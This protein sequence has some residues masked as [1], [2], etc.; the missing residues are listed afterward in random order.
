MRRFILLARK[1][2]LEMKMRM[3]LLLLAALSARVRAAATTA[4][5]STATMTDSL[6]MTSTRTTGGACLKG[7]AYHSGPMVDGETGA[8]TVEAC[9]G[10]CNTNAE[11]SYWDFDGHVCRLR[12]EPGAEGAVD[13]ATATGGAKHCSLGGDRPADGSSKGTAPS[14]KAH[15]TVTPSQGTNDAGGQCRPRP[16]VC[17]RAPLPPPRTAPAPVPVLQRCCRRWCS[18]CTWFSAMPRGGGG[19][20][21]GGGGGGGGGGDLHSVAATARSLS[22]LTVRAHTA[23]AHTA[24]FLAVSVP[25]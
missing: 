17:A 21:G 1:R 5:G 25:E 6:S 16:R 20:V 8:G 3:L 2:A 14:T 18:V 22:T 10:H 19:V 13:D 23:R 12:S 7:K 24:S 11:C 15:R 9:L 4:M